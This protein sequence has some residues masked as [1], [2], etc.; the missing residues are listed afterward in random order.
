MKKFSLFLM[1]TAIFLT[2]SVMAEQ[3]ITDTI[4]VSD[5]SQAIDS[6]KSMDQ[7]VDNLVIVKGEFTEN[8][9]G[10]L[11]ISFYLAAFVFAFLG[12]II[13]HFLIVVPRGIKNTP[14]SPTKMD[15]RY[16]FANNFMTKM[17]VMLTNIIVIFIFLRFSNEWLGFKASMLFSFVLGLSIDWAYDLIRKLQKKVPPPTNTGVVNQ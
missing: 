7:P 9:L 15:W 6:V 4:V 16:W 8:I 3:P 11:T 1:I 17:T 10:S 2:M 14:D 13:R 5:L 12:L